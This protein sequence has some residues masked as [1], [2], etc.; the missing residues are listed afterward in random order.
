MNVCVI[1]AGPAGMRAA[2]VAAASGATVAL[3]DAMPSPGRK[4][5]VAGRGG[6]NI[7]N[8]NAGLPE[9]YGPTG[10]WQSLLAD[11]GPQEL[12]EWVEALGIETFMVS[13]GRIYPKEMKS[14]PLLRRWLCRL[15]AN[16]VRIFPRHRWSGLTRSDQWTLHFSTPEGPK[17][18]SSTAVVFALGGASWP[19]TGSDGSWQNIFTSLGIAVRQLEPANCGW[20]TP[21]LPETSG[22][23]IKN[24]RAS[25]G[26][27][28]AYGEILMTDYGFEGGPIYSLTPTLRLTRLLHLDL[29]PAF[30]HE[31]L[32]ARLPG[33]RPFHLHEAME[34]SRIK[35]PARLLLEHHSLRKTLTSRE[36]FV[37]AIKALP[38]PLSSPRPIAEAISSAGG[39][40]WS[41]LD[42]S[43]MLCNLPGIFVAGEML[44]WEAPTGGYLMQGAFSTGTRAGRAAADWTTTHA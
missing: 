8:R 24:I 3:F 35:G 17:S 39:V 23:P 25:A 40:A 22:L 27:E 18:V 5:L 38:F 36:A 37:A 42:D 2:E 20:E 1:G 43:L 14:A 34:R 15:R 13:S 6:L 12:G 44:D 9:N 31:Q 26:S 7:T 4:F 30:S 11:F 32:L 28:S 41:A 33:N 19:Q 16:G 29:K 21:L 10:P